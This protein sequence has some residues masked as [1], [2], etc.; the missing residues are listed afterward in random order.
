[1]A[2]SKRNRKNRVRK[3]SRRRKRWEISQSPSARRQIH[4]VNR[5]ARKS[6]KPAIGKRFEELVAVQARLRAPGGC[7]WDREQTHASLKTYLIEETYEVLDALETG[8]AKELSEELGDLLLQILFHADLALEAGAFDISDVIK[9]IHDKM[10]RRHPHVFGNL[11]V[12]TSAQ[13]LRNWSQLKAQE[14]EAASGPGKPVALSALDGVSRR[15]PALLEAY[16]LTRRAAQVGFDWE[17]VE[18]IFEKMHEEI[19]ELRVA[20]EASHHRNVEEE[21]GD[22]LFT[23]VNLARFLGIDP[24]VALKHSNLKFKDRFQLMEQRASEEGEQLAR[25]SK[26]EL[27][28]LWEAAK[29]KLSRTLSTGNKL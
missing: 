26:E 7:P 6:A 8:N 1:V 21:L 4:Q 29:V 23:S 12:E 16:Q 13:V 18:G 17:K 28:A 19:S 27:Q 14:K 20:I 5:S 11:K 24:E 2:P 10:I 25:L 15:L 3:K 22:L 9:G